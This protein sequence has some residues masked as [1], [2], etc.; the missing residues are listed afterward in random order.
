LKFT[1]TQRSSRHST[2]TISECHAE[3]PQ[4]TASEGLAQRPYLAA[5][6]GFELATL[7][8]K[9][10]EYTNGVSRFRSLRK[11]FLQSSTLSACG[12]KFC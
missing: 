11:V 12:V 9:G 1:N 5:R 6:A 10:D 2:D 3:A 4:A 8:T 7:R